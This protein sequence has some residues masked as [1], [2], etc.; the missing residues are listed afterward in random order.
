MALRGILTDEDAALRK[1]SRE[2][3]DIDD[4]VRAL[5][6]DMIETMR[7]AGGIGLAAPQVTYL[8]RRLKAQGFDLPDNI[9]RV[10]EAAKAIVEALGKGGDCK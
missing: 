2:V 8:V 6:D 7:D 5:V 1:R 9:I 10:E 4:R 3:A